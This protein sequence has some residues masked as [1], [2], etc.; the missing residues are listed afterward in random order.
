VVG[1]EP[2]TASGIKWAQAQV[3]AHH[4]LHAPVDARSSVEGYAVR[5]GDL[6][7]VGCLL[8]GR[9]QATRCKDWYGSVEDV[10]V[11]RS[12]VTRWQVLNLA[13]VWLTPEVQ[14][15][16]AYCHPDTVP[17]F[18]DRSGAWHSA[19]ASTA[20][21]LLAERV[22]YEYLLARPPVFPDEP[23]EIRWLMSYCD[24]R[25][26][27]GTIY[28]AAGWELYRTNAEGIQTWRTP[29]PPLN[30]HQREQ[31]EGLSWQHARGRRYR[32]M[33][34]EQHEQLALAL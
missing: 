31:I 10:Q 33:R 7:R 9:P 3:A 5:L 16:G 24:T 18:W 21:R 15:G 27:R 14:A 23:Y 34:T 13:R 12:E 17:G 1:L 2:L 8:V 28:A 6:G 19:L 29:L 22:G 32:A 30:A 20:L 25:L 11:G 4:Y 26:H